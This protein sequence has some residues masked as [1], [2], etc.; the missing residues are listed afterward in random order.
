MNPFDRG[1][2]LWL[3]QFAD[4]SRIFDGLVVLLSQTELL[5]GGLALA[6]IW[7]L[8]FSMR[9]DSRALRGRLLA[10]LAGGAVAA[11]ISRLL[12]DVLP[13]RTRPFHEARLPF[14][15]PLTESLNQLRDFSSFPSDH[16]SLFTALSVGVLFCSRRAGIF[17]LFW[18]FVVVLTPRLYLGLHYPTDILAGAALG[19][20]IACLF[21]TRRVR[22]PLAAPLL[23]WQ[24]RHP[25]SFYSGMYLASL[26]IAVLFGDLRDVLSFVVSSIRS[27]RM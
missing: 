25:S 2:I 22:E 20:L 19:T 6:V 17:L 11:L 5:K 18:T 1:L 26:Q 9:E 14:H 10:T 24:D 8:W 12:S 21:Q 23:D 27:G 3:N 7:W 13:F 15:P 4:R 16:A